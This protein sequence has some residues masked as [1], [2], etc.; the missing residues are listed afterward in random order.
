MPHLSATRL[1]PVLVL[2]ACGLLLPAVLEIWLTGFGWHDQQRVFQLVILAFCAFLIVV[3][4]F[5]IHLLPQPALLLLACILLLGL[6]STAFSSHPTWALKE[7]GRYAGLLLLAL[8]ISCSARSV[9]F[10]RAVLYLLCAIAVLNA[11]QFAMLYAMAF[12]SGIFMFKADVFFTGFTNVRFLNQFQMLLMPVL[13]WASLYHWQASHRY[14]RLLVVLLFATLLIHWCIA[15]SLGSRGLWLGLAAAHIALLLF[16]PRFWRQLALQAAAGILGFLLYQLLFFVIPEWLGQE[17]SLRSSMRFGLS[18]RDVIWQTAWDMFKANPWLGIGPMHFSANVTSYAA[19][20]HQVI[21]Q[22][23]AEWGVFA[24]VAA[25]T[26]AVWGMLHGIRFLR[27]K[28]AEPIDAALWL[29]IG[30]ALVLA[31][32]DGVFVIPY[33]ETWLAI[34]AGL[35]MARWSDK[36]ATAETSNRQLLPERLQGYSYKALAVA[37]ILILGN[38]LINET[39]TLPQD[40]QYHMEKHGTGYTPRF[41]MQGWIPMEKAPQELLQQGE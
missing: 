15:F 32:V 29:S 41:W 10:F 6:C 5:K 24:T 14:S 13:A 26:L 39:S 33:T 2:L 16:F 19:H 20:P 23:L 3:P 36:A 11:F 7:W 38:V 35:A 34:L 30:G 40:S 27:G 31:Q 9:W 37:V 4:G 28:S 21:L 8:A 18:K 12:I 22:W 17:A 1:F 25:C